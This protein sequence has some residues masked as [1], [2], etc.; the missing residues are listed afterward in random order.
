MKAIVK[1]HIPWEDPI[2]DIDF[3]NA[4]VPLIGKTIDVVPDPED[5]PDWF[6]ED[7]DYDAVA[8]VF[9]RSWLEFLDE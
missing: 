8:W 9:H 7:S 6:K 3:V 2:D 1:H 4:M 5:G